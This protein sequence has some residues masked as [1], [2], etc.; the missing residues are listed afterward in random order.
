MGPLVLLFFQVSAQAAG[1]QSY[2]E[3]RYADAVAQFTEALKTEAP[4]S[5]EYQESVLMMGESLYLEKKFAEAVPWFQKAA[6]G[7]KRALTAEFML[8]SACLEAHQDDQALQAFSSLFQV[9]PDSAA[10][11]S[12]TAE[13]MLR[14]QQLPDAEREVRRALEL[15]PHLPQAHYMLGLLALAHGDAARAAAEFQSEIQINPG[16][17]MTFY[18]LAEAQAKLGDWDDAISSLERAIWLN[19]NQV[20]PYLLLG[21]AYLNRGSLSDAE[22]ALRQVLAMDPGN[23]RARDLLARTLQRAGQPQPPAK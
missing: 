14:E 23:A 7:G 2:R 9:K 12:L 4:G 18:R 3:H 6:A 11:H 15:D 5:A 19:P 1:I 21:E 20:G 17:P 13:M 10:A 8:G 16:F 22:G